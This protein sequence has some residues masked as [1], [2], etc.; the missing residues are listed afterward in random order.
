MCFRAR[1]QRPYPRNR[2]GSLPP[3]LA[4]R[5]GVQTARRETPLP[6]PENLRASLIELRR[7]GYLEIAVHGGQAWVDYGPRSREIAEKWGIAIEGSS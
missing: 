6:A 4:V 5:A 3:P 7:V 1:S 2:V